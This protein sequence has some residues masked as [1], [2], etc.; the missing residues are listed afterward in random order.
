M[1]R[2]TE[3]IG[4]GVDHDVGSNHAFGIRSSDAGRRR[5]D[6][7]RG[8]PVREGSARRG[9]AST[10]VM[11]GP[12]RPASRLS[13]ACVPQNS[14]RGDWLPADRF[15]SGGPGRRGRRGN[16]G[17]RANRASRTAAHPRHDSLQHPAPR[18]AAG[19]RRGGRQGELG[20]R[21]GSLLHQHVRDERKRA[22]LPRAARFPRAAHAGR[23]G[24]HPGD[25][26]GRLLRRR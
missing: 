7:R 14:G 8:A 15:P 4:K 3:S 18:H 20:R 24:R 1:D 5:A 9:S 21:G 12:A 13:E 25:G 19:T 10:E 16:R 17:G 6:T 22:Q 26:R 11:D 23:R 2:E